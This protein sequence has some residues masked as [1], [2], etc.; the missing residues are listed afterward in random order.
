MFE[1]EVKFDNR[2]WENIFNRE[3]DEHEAIKL[4][5]E[6]TRIYSD[7]QWRIVYKPKGGKK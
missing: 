1:V 5:T 4:F 3:L 2:Y 6:S 7:K